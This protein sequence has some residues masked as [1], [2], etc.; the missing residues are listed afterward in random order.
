MLAHVVAGKMNKAIAVDLGTSEQNVKVHRGRAM[1][2]MGVR[3][4]AE[5]VRVAERLGL[6]PAA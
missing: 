4:I 3:S 6:S 2:K 1:R 5:R